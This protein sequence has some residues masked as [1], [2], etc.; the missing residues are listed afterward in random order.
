[1]V[2]KLGDFLSEEAKNRLKRQVRPRAAAASNPDQSGVHIMTESF[3][4]LIEK[5]G[6][7][8]FDKGQELYG[9][10][11]QS[12]Q[13][14][15]IERKIKPR[16]PEGQLDLH[17]E[18]MDEAVRKVEEF[19]NGMRQAGYGWVLI[20]TGAGRHSKDGLPRL[21]PIVVR[22]LNEMKEKQRIKDFQT[23]QQRHGGMGA[24][25]VYLR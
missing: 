1:M 5:Q 4:E 12:T 13:P 24:I 21:R 3:K 18:T 9:D 14:G 8:G 16:E 6:L 23:A 2:S 20:I 25:Y 22:K 17:G 7:A 15:R 11:D 19:V 10:P